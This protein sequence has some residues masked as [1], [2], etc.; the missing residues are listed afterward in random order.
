L[1]GPK[2]ALAISAAVQELS[3]NAA[4]YGAFSISSGKLNVVWTIEESG[5]V[6]LK[7][8]ERE[9]PIVRKPSRRGF[10]TKMITSIFD[11]EE[12][13]SVKLEFE[14]G[15]LCCDMRFWPQDEGQHE[16]KLMAAAS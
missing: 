6:H 11:A 13:W 5:L 2:V 16:V 10:G 9:G 14:R 3:T 15:G 1:L 7:W 4:K 12:G 8:I